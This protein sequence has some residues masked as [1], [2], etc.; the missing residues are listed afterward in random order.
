MEAKRR[1]QQQRFATPSMHD[2]L[3]KHL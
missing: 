1:Q 3:L 2:Q